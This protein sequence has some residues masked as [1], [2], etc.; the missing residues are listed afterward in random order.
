MPWIFTHFGYDIRY[1][2]FDILV[3]LDV[4]YSYGPMKDTLLD[5]GF[6]CQICIWIMSTIFAGTVSTMISC[7]ISNFQ[8]LIKVLKKEVSR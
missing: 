1:I 5:M 4:C 3:K 6:K 8:I 7:Y 2:L